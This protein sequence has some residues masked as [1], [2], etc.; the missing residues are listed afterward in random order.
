MVEKPDKDVANRVLAFQRNEITEHMIYNALSKRAKGSNSQILKKM[1]ED[2]LRHYGEWR[3]YTG[4]DVA[5]SRLMLFKILLVARLF[6]LTFAV[7]LMEKGE[8]EAEEVYEKI[9]YVFAKAKEIMRDE[10]E[11]EEMLIGMIDEEMVKYVGS[12]V[13]GLNDA[14]VEL[15]GALVGLTFT[16]QNSRLVGVAG[17][18]TGIAA[19]L[20]MSASEYLSQRSE[21]SE[22]NPLKA[23]LYTGIAYL[24]TVLILS[25]PFLILP[26]YRLS[27]SIMFLSISLIVSVFTFFISITKETSFRRMFLEMILISLGV[28]AV[29]FVIGWFARI[30]FG[31]EV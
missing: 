22:K 5:P 1:S 20:S 14:L 6:G 16:L 18:V 21:K 11:H 3:E 28:A 7:K 12:L 25:A 8:K 19:S 9:S 29:S 4:R 13:L 2:E 24:A 10:K 17:L 26:D 30:L 15:T 23:S 27:L 31:I